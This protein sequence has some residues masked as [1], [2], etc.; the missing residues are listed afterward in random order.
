[1]GNSSSNENPVADSPDK[2]KE[3][4]VSFG[5]N[6][7]YPISPRSPR[8]ENIKEDKN[9]NYGDNNNNDE[10]SEESDDE[11]FFDEENKNENGYVEYITSNISD[12]NTKNKIINEMKSLNNITDDS[13]TDE[14]IK[15]NYAKKYDFMKNMLFVFYKYLHENNE[16][17][18]QELMKE[19]IKK[20]QSIEKPN[21]KSNENT[22]GIIAENNNERLLK[23]E[24]D[25]IELKTPET[26]GGRAKRRRKT[27]R[28]SKKCK[29]SRKSIRRR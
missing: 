28:K 11:G 4:I 23:T 27:F 3:K 10:D 26:K 12:Q 1:M 9:T 25:N 7:I 22:T 17:K 15:Q 13:I 21:N 8:S 14:L 24:S 18:I 5:K 16:T 29:N 20:F 2:K 19:A 6:I